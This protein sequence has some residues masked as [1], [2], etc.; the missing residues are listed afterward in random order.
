MEKNLPWAW[1]GEQRILLVRDD[2]EEQHIQRSGFKLV[3]DE[4]RLLEK[5]LCLEKGFV[6]FVNLRD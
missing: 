5:G 2:G 4:H 1:F 6:S 3:D